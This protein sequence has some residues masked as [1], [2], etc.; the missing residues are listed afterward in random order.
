MPAAEM[1]FADQKAQPGGRWLLEGLLTV[2]M[3]PC[4]NC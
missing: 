3:D 4:A 2:S 1:P